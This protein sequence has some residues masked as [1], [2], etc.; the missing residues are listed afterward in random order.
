MSTLG[1]SFNKFINSF[2]SFSNGAIF[3]KIV[4]NIINHIVYFFS[5]R[6]DSFHYILSR[7]DHIVHL[8]YRF[9]D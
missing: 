6:L 4:C 8:I 2:H 5:H 9:L 3:W 7:V 1:N